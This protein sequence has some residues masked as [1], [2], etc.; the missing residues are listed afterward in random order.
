MG[1]SVDAVFGF[2][3]RA[4]NLSRGAPFDQ[5]DAFSRAHAGDHLVG[6]TVGLGL[7]KRELHKITRFWTKVCNL[8][9]N[10]YL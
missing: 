1:P 5:G 7:R 10:C 6:F 4:G 3:I 2:S 8:S 9:Y